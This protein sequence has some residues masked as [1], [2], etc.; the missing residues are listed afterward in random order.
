M[1][2]VELLAPAGSMEALIA[3]VQNGC[4]AVYLGGSMFGAR[5]FANNFDEEEMRSAVRYAHGY[6]VKVYVTMNTLIKEKEMTQALT[7]AKFLYELQVDALIIQDLGFF[8]L[9]HQECPD[10]EL[11]AS[12]QMHIHNPQGITFMKKAGAKRVVVPRETPIEEIAQFATLGIDLEVFVQGALC[13]S[14]SGQCLMSAKKLSRSGN[15]G[16]CAQMCRMR[17]NLV[18]EENGKQEIVDVDGEYLLS[19]KDLNTLSKVPELIQ[20]GIASF[21][22]EGRMKRPAYVALMVSLY[23]QAI[24]AYYAHKPYETAQADIEMRKIFNRD[25]T[26]G[27]LFH[28]RGQALMNFHRPNHMG[29]PVGKV[30]FGKAKRIS[31]VLQDTLTQGDGIR[32]LGAKEDQGCMVNKLYR[33]GLLVKEA[34]KGECVEIEYSGYVEKGSMV[35]KTS[36]KNQLDALG[37]T[38]TKPQRKIGLRMQVEMKIGK[39]F[40]I[41][42][43]D[44]EGFTCTI[45][46]E[47]LVEQALTTPLDKKRVD[48]QCRKCGDTIFSVNT[49]SI[50]M[51]EQSTISI[52]EINEV[53]RSALAK[54][55]QKREQR[56]LHKQMGSYHRE[57]HCTQRK[58]ILAVV[59]TEDQAEVLREYA[60]I[61]VFVEGLDR[62]KKLKE[63]GEHVDYHAPRVMKQEYPKEA[64]M[65]C[66]VGGIST[67][68]GIAD[69]FVNVTNSYAAAFLFAHGIQGIVV[70]S[71]LSPV[72]FQQLKDGFQTR[73]GIKGNFIVPAYGKEELMISEYCAIQACYG[74]TKK[75]CGICK[76]K[77][78]FYLEDVQGHQYPL[79]QDE[80]CRMHILDEQA[81]DQIT[82]YQEESILL[83]F[84]NETQDEVQRIC[85]KALSK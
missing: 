24:D 36:D 41:H 60:D 10:F 76:G 15:R 1:R 17:Y 26:S 80:D 27:H 39:P 4:D 7:Y 22:I 3:A 30:S 83:S 20:A 18:K 48:K 69:H 58:Q 25:F 9:V 33:K 29:I 82:S 43:E 63:A 40:Y 14:Y 62:Y 12:T 11:H 5:A 52:K 64:C 31:V 49:L 66:E 57:I 85:K 53:R 34:Y 8:D 56:T 50:T 61:Q 13:V 38:I 73:Y 32:F 81:V 47:R 55:T 35:V 79:Y 44:E 78:S 59:H 23:R 2:K 37:M 77:A 46:S 68:K 54:L 75:N 67:G 19:P 65:F 71:E 51:E 74:K 72:E 84:A 21:K 45:E 6:G 42:V 16:E 70:S 28:Q